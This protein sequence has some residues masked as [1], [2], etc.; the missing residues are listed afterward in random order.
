MHNDVFISSPT[1]II[2]QM[3][4]F[5]TALTKT[6]KMEACTSR[7]WEALCLGGEGKAI[8]VPPVCWTSTL[9][10]R[11]PLFVLLLIYACVSSAH[12]MTI[13]II[14]FSAIIIL[15]LALTF[16]RKSRCRHRDDLAPPVLG[17][18]GTRGFVWLCLPWQNSSLCAMITSWKKDFKQCLSVSTFQ[19]VFC[20]VWILIFTWVS[21]T[22]HNLCARNK[23]SG[24][25]DN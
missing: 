7:V 21:L 22:Q 2:Y 1:V 11:S 16:T 23:E 5:S 25:S 9:C 13:L 14:L 3:S 10:R 17:L 20:F 18:R 6:F 8:C 15:V 24:P 4:S 19:E 12:S